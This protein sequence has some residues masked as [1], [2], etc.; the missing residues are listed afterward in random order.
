MNVRLALAGALAVTAAVAGLIVATRPGTDAAESAQ[1]AFA[2]KPRI[3]RPPELPRDRVLS[4]RLENT[5]LEQVDVDVRDIS[6]LDESGR[7]LRSS[8]RFATVFAHGL[9][10]PR[11]QTG[12]PGEFERR[13]LGELVTLKP[14]RSTP[15]TVSWRGRAGDLRVSGERL[16]LPAE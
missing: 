7:E 13:R 12:D 16:E 2:G 14:R 1:L 8:A 15:L 4:V 5:G 10:S 6:V 3:V 11:E 9:I